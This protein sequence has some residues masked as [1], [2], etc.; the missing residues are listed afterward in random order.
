MEPYECTDGTVLAPSQ[1]AALEER[2]GWKTVV[3][4]KDG[5]GIMH[6]VVEN[7]PSAWDQAQRALTERFA[8]ADQWGP[9]WRPRLRTVK[10][11]A[12]LIEYREFVGRPG[13][14]KGRS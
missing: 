14:Q 13:V 9:G 2:G 8:D 1:Q 4:W 10:K 3:T 5:H 7:A 6:A 12:M 11:T